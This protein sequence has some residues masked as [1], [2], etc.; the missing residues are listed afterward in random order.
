MACSQYDNLISD[1]SFYAKKAGH[2][3]YR[4]NKTILS[5]ICARLSSPA[6]KTFW[7]KNINR[8]MKSCGTI[9]IVD[10]RLV[11]TFGGQNEI[12]NYWHWP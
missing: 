5:Y 7:N 1:L 9:L 3:N 4:V 11:T 8:W 12:C 2:S 10:Y 6:G